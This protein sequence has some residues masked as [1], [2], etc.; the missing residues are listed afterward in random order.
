MKRPDL[1]KGFDGWQAIDATPQ[2]LSQ[3]K[4]LA[5]DPTVFAHVNSF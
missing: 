4:T 5:Q 3:G 1:P 2:E